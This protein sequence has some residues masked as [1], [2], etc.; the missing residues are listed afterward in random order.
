MFRYFS[1]RAEKTEQIWIWQT[2]QDQ[3]T[4]S[5]LLLLTRLTQSNPEK[6][7]WDMEMFTIDLAVTQ[8]QGKDSEFKAA[9]DKGTD[10]WILQ[11]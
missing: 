4:L 6:E 11:T 5:K 10:N 8:N 7:S 3:G 9:A 2:S 1:W